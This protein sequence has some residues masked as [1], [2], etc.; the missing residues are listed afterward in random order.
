MRKP[1]LPVLTTSPV[2][3]LLTTVTKYAC[4][5]LSTAA[6]GSASRKRKDEL[7]V[8]Q[9]LTQYMFRPHTKSL[10]C[11]YLGSRALYNH[12]C[13]ITHAAGQVHSEPRVKDA[14]SAPRRSRG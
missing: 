6:T 11:V 9:S 13:Y 3:S 2:P 12:K 7:V 4:G 5:S 8:M 10:R 14:E 1:E